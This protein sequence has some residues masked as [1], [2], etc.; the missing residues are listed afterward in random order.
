MNTIEELESDYWSRPPEGS[1]NL[2]LKCHSL[3]KKRIADFSIEDLR[4]MVG[5]KIGLKYLIPMALTYLRG[6]P[7]AEGDFYEG[8]LLENVLKVDGNFWI[9]NP[10]FKSELD[11]MQIRRSTIFHI[12]L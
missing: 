5:Q 4:L 8:D 10:Q 1:S 9:D 3:R 11:G 7:F 2:V 12:C 6:N